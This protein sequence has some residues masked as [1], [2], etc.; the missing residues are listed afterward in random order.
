VEGGAEGG[1]RL[2]GLVAGLR[3]AEHD[4]CIALPVDCPLV[5][6]ELLT[7]LADACE[8]D[9]AMPQTGPLPGAFRQSALPVLERRLVAGELVLRDA[10]IELDAAV[11]ELD[12]SLLVNVNLPEDLRHVLR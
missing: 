2:G 4:V 10:L 8:G 9:A 6:A 3:A 7:G 5:T 1:A 12:S 11:I